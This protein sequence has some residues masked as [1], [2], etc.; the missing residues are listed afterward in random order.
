MPPESRDELVNKYTNWTTL[1]R[2]G[3]H[4]DRIN[5]ENKRILEDNETLAKKVKDLES[6]VKRIEN[7]ETQVG[8]LQSENQGMK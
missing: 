3:F 2:C 5:E 6:D 7:L 4:M 1:F 8:E